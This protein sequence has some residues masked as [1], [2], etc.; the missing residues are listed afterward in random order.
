M[1][2]RCGWS[3]TAPC[4]ILCATQVVR[5]ALQ[6]AASVAEY[7]K[8]EAPVLIPVSVAW[9]AWAAWTSERRPAPASVFEAEWP[10]G[11]NA[12]RCCQ[13]HLPPQHF[14]LH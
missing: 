13:L 7:P 10:E 3:Q 12:D 14:P 6:D 5:T 9:A 2:T 11:Q 8:K 4:Y 1:Q